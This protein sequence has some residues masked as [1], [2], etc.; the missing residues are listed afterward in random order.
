[1][2]YLT[3]PQEFVDVWGI[4]IG[5]TQFPVRKEGEAPPLKDLNL[6][7]LLPE[8][9]FLDHGL[10]R[11]VKIEGVKVSIGAGASINLKKCSYCGR[12]LPLGPG[13]AGR[14]AFHKHNA[15]LSGHQNECR[16]CKKWR[17]NDAFN[18][19]RTV[20]QLNESST[21]TR[22]RKILLQEPSILQTIKERSGRGLK[23]I[24]W[25][26]F[27]RRCFYCEKPLNLNDVQLDHTRPL[28]YLWP[29]DE[30]AT[31]L[32]A[33]HNNEKKDKFPVDF[34]NGDQLK[35]LATITGLSLDKLIA[36]EVCEI[37]LQR[38]RADI[39]GFVGLCDPRTF[40]AISR[41]VF[42]IRPDVDLWDELEQ[43]DP[44]AYVAAKK[45][46]AF[47]PTSVGE[48]ENLDKLLAALEDE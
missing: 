17:I 34:Y 12:R 26:R 10:T 14:L 29:I 5:K 42:E 36:R 24:V 4:T 13:Q 19:L 6:T 8:T 47:R 25:D 45:A 44:I 38:I 41:K 11:D 23:S 18:P 21:I 20:D 7:H 48:I 27:G 31:C 28:A 40:N 37:H 9:L 46:Q 2:Q 22:E 43:A 39:S 3:P 15:K 16:A 35:R 32:C 33:E 1:M 30:H